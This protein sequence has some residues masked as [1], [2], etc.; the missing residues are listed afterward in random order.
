MK[1]QGVAEDPY[2]RVAG[3]YDRIFEPVNRNLRL[4]GLRMFVPRRGAAILDVGCGTGAHLAL[5]QR[6]AGRLA[7]VDASV[8]MLKQARLRLGREADLRLADAATLPFGD[9][10]FDLVV[11]MLTLHEMDHPVRTAVLAEIQRVTRA[12][13]RIL[14]I[15][16][17]PGRSRRLKGWATKLLI[18]AAEVSA[19]RRHFRNYRH[20]L[21]I[22]GLPALIGGTHLTSDKL[23][24]V[25]GDTMDLLLCRRAV[26]EAIS[27]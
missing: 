9:R 24:V 23:R 21:R 2:R 15:D 16:F 17:H 14:L 11:S 18:L 19:G 20:F 12:D 13:G 27:A 4:M 10:E 7:G 22:G 25:G 8:A 26:D 5:Y 3:I 6:Y 1:E